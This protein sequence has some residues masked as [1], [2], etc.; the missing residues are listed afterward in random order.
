MKDKGIRLLAA[1]YF[2]DFIYLGFSVF[3]SKYLAEINLSESSIGLLLSVPSLVGMCFMPLFGMLS[4]RM[5]YKKTLVVIVDVC[6]A[7]TLFFVDGFTD[8]TSEP[9]VTRFLPLLC[10]LTL[11]AICLQPVMPSMNAISIEYAES[12]GKAFGP[13]RM[14]G[15]IGYQVGLLAIGFI[16]ATSLRHI[17][18]YQA[19]GI[20]A[21][22]F[23]ACFLPNV[24]GKQYGGKKV[25]PFA[26]LKN[27]NV[28][29]LLI[30]VLVATCS[31]MFYQTFLGAFYER[32]GMTNMASS[33]VTWIAVALEIP[34]LFFANKLYKRF[35]VWK[36]MLIG[37]IITGVRWLG[38]FLCARIGSWQ[39]LILF[40]LPSVTATAC[41]EFFPQLYLGSVA[42]PALTSSAQTML[43]FTSFG[44]AKVIGGLLG[45]FISD[46]VGLSNMFGIYGVMLL[47][48]AAVFAPLIFRLAAQEKRTAVARS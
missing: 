47:A 21:A 9:P 13:I 35:G 11:N 45:G 46:R 44:V 15:T 38:F 22:A 12:K 41:F 37:L 7:I 16:C 18:T 43:N 17:Y 3:S 4:D 1:F 20:L 32:M 31:T 6:A 24:G 42:D 28:L 33:V 27:R 23:V 8:F 10:V 25:S 14:C 48:A 36:W 40:Q 34:M 39:L 30:M 26:V 5:R 29:L 19:F 2:I